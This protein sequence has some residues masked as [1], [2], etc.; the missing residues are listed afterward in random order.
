M[1]E[2]S[3]I[4]E[5]EQFIEENENCILFASQELEEQLSKGLS[6]FNKGLRATSEEI[7]LCFKVYD[8]QEK[9]MNKNIQYRVVK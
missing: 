7:E 9:M 1:R 5:M 8:L 3:T 4:K 2:V 6:A